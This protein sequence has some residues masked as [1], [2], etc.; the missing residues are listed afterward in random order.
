MRGRSR[1]LLLATGFALLLSGCGGSDSSPAPTPTPKPT[2]VSG[3][4]TGVTV[5]NPSVRGIVNQSAKTIGLYL[6]AGAAVTSV[7]PTIA[8]N[9]GSSVLPASGQPQDFTNPVTYTVTGPDKKAVVYTAT[10]YT[11]EPTPQQVATLL[12]NGINLGNTLDAP[13]EGDWAAAAQEYYFTDYKS[14]GFDSVRIPITWNAH[15]GT[16]S[17]F[18]VQA[19]FMNRVDQIAGWGIDRGMA[20]VIN[21]HHEDWIRAVNDAT[22]AAQKPRF[23]ALWTQIAE[24]FANWPPQLVFEILNE[25][26]TPMTNASVNDLN[27]TILGI[28][29]QSNPTRTVIIGGNSYNAISS[30]QAS[31]FVI[32]SDSHLIATF[33]Y[34]NPWNF[35]GQAIGTWGSASDISTLNN[36]MSTVAAWAAS[37]SIPLYMG[38]YG[39]EKQC[40]AASRI[41]WYTE[42]SIAART[43]HI[44]YIAWDDSGDFGIFNRA[45]G[46]FETPILKAIMGN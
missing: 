22:Y 28:I 8:L 45:G 6:P 1:F 27:A 33:H 29:R 7:A 17:P 40:D 25:P 23:V 4:I 44:P 39:A 36:D 13:Q 14:A 21:A 18:A 42:L 24:H 46:T 43:N 12:G 11:T 37:H 26:R 5:S 30:I 19:D 9:S 15:F 20:V 32:P 35:C 16:V 10:A 34:Y 31:D 38:E 3:V 2:T 41:V